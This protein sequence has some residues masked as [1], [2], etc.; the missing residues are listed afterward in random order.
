M[1]FALRAFEFF[2]EV[3]ILFLGLIPNPHSFS[4]ESS[5]SFLFK[6]QNASV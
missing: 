1:S 6:G 3:S 2:S 4:S 5:M